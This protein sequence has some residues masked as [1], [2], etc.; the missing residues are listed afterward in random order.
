MKKEMVRRK[1]ERLAGSRVNDAVK[2][3]FLDKKG[4]AE[5]GKMDLSAVAEFRRSSTGTVEIKFVDRL[6]ALK[7]LA[8]TGEESREGGII[9]ALEKSA[10]G[11]KE[12]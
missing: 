6:A 9:E 2:L 8:E 11:L 10:E 5:L 1:I 4:L 12:E 3:A 7:W